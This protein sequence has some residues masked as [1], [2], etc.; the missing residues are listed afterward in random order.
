MAS[1]RPDA[2]ALTGQAGP[3]HGQT[4]RL[5][6][7]A[8]KSGTPLQVGACHAQRPCRQEGEES[9]PAPCKHIPTGLTPPSA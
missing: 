5:C 2:T 4:K 8:Q 7:T 9:S 6:A 1:H 3:T